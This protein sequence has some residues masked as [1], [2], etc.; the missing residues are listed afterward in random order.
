MTS[1]HDERG[2]TLLEALFAAALLIT[3]VA[4]TAALI[5][6]AH[7]VGVQSEQ[8]TTATV[9]AV[10]RL[11]ALRSVPW[12]YEI[13]GTAP[14][15]PALAYSPSGAL[16]QDTDGYWDAVDEAGRPV[17]APQDGAAFVRRWAV[18]PALSGSLQTRSLEVCVFRWPADRDADPLVCVADART[19]QP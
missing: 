12:R 1:L 10:A 11:Q 7:R 15:A 8:T 9:L 13:D 14:E 18:S 19:R 6:L 4:G 5:V 2:T 3:L 16:D 17:V